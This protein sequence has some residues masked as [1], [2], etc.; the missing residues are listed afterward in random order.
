MFENSA[1]VE[2]PV[3]GEEDI[4][5]IMGRCV[6]PCEAECA[7]QLDD[8]QCGTDGRTY[9]NSCYRTCASTSVRVMYC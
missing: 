9:T 1:I 5:K 4:L 8:I 3:E 7:T 6:E 2:L